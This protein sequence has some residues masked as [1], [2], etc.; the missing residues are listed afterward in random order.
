MRLRIT[1]LSGAFRFGPRFQIA[2]INDQTPASIDRAFTYDGIGRLTASA[3]P[4]GAGTDEYDGLGNIR[5][6]SVGARTVGMSYSAANQLSSHTDTVLVAPAPVNM[7]ARHDG[8]SRRVKQVGGDAVF[9]VR[10]DLRRLLSPSI[11]PHP[12]TAPAQG[13]PH[14]RHSHSPA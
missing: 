1:R 4:W 13:A 11:A 14:P 5:Q 8:A 2:S 7:A 3:G 9:R 6:R 12:F 10:F